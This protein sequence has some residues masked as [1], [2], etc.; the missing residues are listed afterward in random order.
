MT[1]SPNLELRKEWE[2]R[3]TDCKASGQTQVKWCESNDISIH[4][5]RY[6]MKRIKDTND[7]KKTNNS[8]VP[9]VI[10]DAKTNVSDSLLL[11]VGSVSIEVNPDFN[12]TLLTEVIKVLKDNVE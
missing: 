2:K 3:I 8:W 7:A 4:Q 6:W 12:P 9:L 1:K 10:E 11:K 5:F